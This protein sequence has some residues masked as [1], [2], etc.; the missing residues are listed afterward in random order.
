MEDDSSNTN[1]R[2]CPACGQR[3]SNSRGLKNDFQLLSCQVCATLYTAT[4][5]ELNEQEDYDAYYTSENL[6]VPTF[7]NSILDEIVATFEPYR[8]N[9]L[10]LDVGCGAGTF[11]EAAA[12]AGWDATGVEVSRTAAD[13]VT[14]K[15]FEVF[16]GELEKA[17]Y[18]DRHFDV[19][20][21]SEV[22]EHVPDPK[23]LLKASAK[24]LR[25]GG[26]LWGTTPHGRGI[27]AR[28]LGLGWSIVCP[29]EHLQ[30]FSLAGMKGLLS[31]AGFKQ[32]E[33]ATHGTNPFEILHALRRGA[34]YP[35]PAN[36]STGSES[37]NRVESSY[38]L[39][40]F[41]SDSPLRRL[42]KTTLN[43]LLNVGRMGDSLKI[44]AEK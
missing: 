16:C 32:V 24:V 9:N 29:P 23:A 10:L 26:L 3:R 40:E 18:P 19:V 11:L 37:F 42:L 14:S 27:S 33:L 41:L 38:Q 31:G 7:I 35:A 21:L 5:P 34:T 15:G 13:H 2:D 4:N 44:R 1:K 39:N 25:P 36:G 20:I 28:I 22:L 6:T 30:L 43:S 8:N 12:R 17:G